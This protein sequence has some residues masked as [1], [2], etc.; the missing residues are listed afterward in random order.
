MLNKPKRVGKNNLKNNLVMLSFPKSI[1]CDSA[2]LIV[3]FTP[4]FSGCKI[5]KAL[6]D[7]RLH[8]IAV[9]GVFRDTQKIHVHFIAVLGTYREFGL[10]FHS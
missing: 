4:I 8:F 2:L 6:S 10:P 1:A 7:R 9:L 3:D 5:I